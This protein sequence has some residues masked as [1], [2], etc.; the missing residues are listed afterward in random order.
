M[1]S[2]IIFLPLPLIIL[3]IPQFSPVSLAHAIQRPKGP[4]RVRDLPFLNQTESIGGC[5]SEGSKEIPSIINPLGDLFRKGI[6]ALKGIIPNSDS[7]SEDD[8]IAGTDEEEDKDDNGDLF[9]CTTA[10]VS[11][12]SPFG[13]VKR[14]KELIQ[15]AGGLRKVAQAVFKEPSFDKLVALGGPLGNLAK[16]F[17]GIPDIKEKCF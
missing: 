3:A 15:E 1:R 5:V 8:E 14:A 10:I 17:L 9:D 4:F 12:I 13:K 7:G 16:E 11:A 2:S 6:E